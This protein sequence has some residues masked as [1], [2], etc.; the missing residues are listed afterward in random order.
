MLYIH[1]VLPLWPG[2]V[3]S[4]GV[5]GGVSVLFPRPIRV[6]ETKPEVQFYGTY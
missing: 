5:G 1:S 2:G 6:S 3:G 4:G